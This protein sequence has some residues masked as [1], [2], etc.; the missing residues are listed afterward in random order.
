M[1]DGW[2]N[3]R[4]DSVKLGHIYCAELRESCKE[5][6]DG[7]SRALLLFEVSENG[8]A[9][10]IEALDDDKCGDGTWSFQGG[11]RTFYR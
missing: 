4:W 2:V 5:D 9:L 10:I 8:R 11:E 6:G 1:S 3:R 7:S